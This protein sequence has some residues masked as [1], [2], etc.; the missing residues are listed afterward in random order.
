MINSKIALNE[1][2]NTDKKK[3]WQIRGA[4]L[5][6]R[7]NDMSR[8]AIAYIVQDRIQ[9]IGPT[10]LEIIAGGCQLVR[11]GEPELCL[12]PLST[13][14]ALHDTCSDWGFPVVFETI[15]CG[16]WVQRINMLNGRV[17]TFRI[18]VR[19]EFVWSLPP[20]LQH[21][22]ADPQSPMI[23]GSAAICLFA[24]SITCAMDRFLLPMT[25][26]DIIENVFK[27][28]TFESVLLYDLWR[29]TADY[30]VELSI[31][32]ENDDASPSMLLQLTRYKEHVCAFACLPS[33]SI[34]IATSHLEGFSAP[35]RSSRFFIVHLKTET[36]RQARGAICNNVPR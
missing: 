27:R 15:D 3:S 22:V 16:N 8:P 20:L 34:F 7:T 36:M 24:D 31:T 17:D 28:L 10:K 32:K 33:G 14:T 13:P 26:N 2:T 23:A 5:T 4:R 19:G 29:I 18:R 6:R 30:C 35:P 21:V 12:I 25:A 11:W 9:T 1:Q